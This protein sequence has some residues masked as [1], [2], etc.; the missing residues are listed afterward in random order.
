MFGSIKYNLSHL[1]DFT[2]RDARQ[3]FWYYVLFL[4]VVQVG[5]GIVLMI[6]MY[7]DIFGQAFSA[8]QSGMSEQEMQAAMFE[9]MAGGLRT[10]M[11]ASTILGLVIAALFAA[12]F[13]RRLH[14]SGKSGWWTLLA[15]GTYLASLAFN[16]ANIDT[17]LEITSRS[18][19]VT[20]PNEALSVQGELYAYS[21]LGWVGYVV[22]IVFGVM[23]SDPGPN[24]YGAEP[25]R[26]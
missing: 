12:S 9:G 23:K 14:D 1:T 15:L 21:A 8:A 17:V 11:Y 5:V 13:T 2:G 24:E 19:S 4:V 6:P 25:V 26:F 16:V 22:V 3:T 7:I 20:D 10:Q 18:M